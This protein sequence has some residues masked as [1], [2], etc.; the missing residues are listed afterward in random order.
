MNLNKVPAVRNAFLALASIALIIAVFAATFE[1]SRQRDLRPSDDNIW[2][3]MTGAELRNP[4]SAETVR[5]I[6]LNDVIPRTASEEGAK[7]FIMR[8]EYNE[9]YYAHSVLLG[10]VNPPAD[11]A[12]RNGVLPYADAIS[13]GTLN[14]TAV[15]AIISLT[16]LIA[17]LVVTRRA[18]FLTA[19]A[20]AMVILALAPLF[21]SAGNFILFESL[22]PA[23]FGVNLVRFLINPGEQFL[24]FGFTPRN[25]MF[26]LTLVV[27]AWRWAGMWAASYWF[28]AALLIVHLSLGAL[29][30]AILVAI[31]LLLRREQFLRLHIVA[32]LAFAA[33]FWAGRESLWEYLTP[34]LKV[35]MPVLVGL[36]A[37]VALIGFQILGR[38]LRNHPL[39]TSVPKL[40]QPLQKQPSYLSDAA[41]ISVG[42]LVLLPITYAISASMDP[43]VAKY[44]WAQ[45]NARLYALLYP[46][47]VFAIMLWA[48]H[49]YALKL[50][51]RPWIAPLA[52]GAV[53]IAF[54]LQAP[55]AAE[56]YAKFR[57]GMRIVAQASLNPITGPITIGDEAVI[58]FA[59]SRQIE[60]DVPALTDVLSGTE[61][62]ATAASK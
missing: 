13:E 28:A 41:I 29:F 8:V 16:L 57:E 61:A 22:D 53:A 45:L 43:V 4:A 5:N 40:L 19:A 25:Y 55:R 27:F 11:T 39:M 48:F 42:W 31:D 54:L 44:F 26:L 14:V 33:V 62:P 21:S 36:F 37:L 50:D 47:I 35:V 6:V 10:L 58:Y 12:A 32:P 15:A 46:A 24:I 23:I 52:C 1:R 60:G 56:P 38:R 2:F 34:S 59:A 30:I 49:K 17:G 20:F 51:Q 9:N 7:R 18:Y 3:Y